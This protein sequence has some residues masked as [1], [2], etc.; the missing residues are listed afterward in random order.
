MTHIVAETLT[1]SY[2]GPDFV[3][4]WRFHSVFLT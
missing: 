2:L 4:P 1:N 3:I